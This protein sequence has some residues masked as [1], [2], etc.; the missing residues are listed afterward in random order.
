MLYSKKM[1]I[2]LSSGIALVGR[3]ESIMVMQDI[4][5]DTP[6]VQ[7]THLSTIGYCI[8]QVFIKSGAATRGGDKG[9]PEP[10]AL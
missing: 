6:C 9:P 1:A 5:L 7:C 8:Y 4:F 10:E 3:E 2:R